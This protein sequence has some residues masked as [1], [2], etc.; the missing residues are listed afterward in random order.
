MATSEARG[1]RVATNN[2]AH[3]SPTASPWVGGS[4]AR[5]PQSR[6]QTK[7]TGPDLNPW[8]SSRVATSQVRQRVETNDFAH[9]SPTACPWVGVSV[10]RVDPRTKPGQ[11][12]AELDPVPEQVPEQAK[13]MQ[14]PEQSHTQG[15]PAAASTIDP[16]T[17]LIEE[18][19]RELAQ[20]AFAEY[21][22]D[23]IDEE[24]LKRRK[25]AAREKAAAEYCL[26]DAQYVY[27]QAT[28]ARVDAEKAFTAAVMA[29][30][31]AFAKLNRL[32]QAVEQ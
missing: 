4:E 31:E 27:V 15:K 30:E 21:F 9:G 5:A 24:E 18:R 14:E 25:A 28:E 17:T 29:E 19:A 32:Q 16:V 1:Q 11:R 3:G 2:F 26:E 8:E 23:M 22:A 7:K 10:A 6:P 13:P 20:N 12:Q